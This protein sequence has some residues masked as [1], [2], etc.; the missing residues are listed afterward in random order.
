VLLIFLICL[1]MFH[2]FNLIHTSHHLNSQTIYFFLL[3]IS[4]T[5]TL[6]NLDLLSFF[7]GTKNFHISY[8]FSLV[9]F[10]NLY[11]KFLLKKMGFDHHVI[12]ISLFF[13][14]I[15]SWILQGLV[16]EGRNIHKQSGFHK[17][18]FFFCLPSKLLFCLSM[19][20]FTVKLSELGCI[21]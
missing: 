21:I 14:V 10:Y 6:I 17:V 5:L 20:E 1:S 2:H 8:Y 12:C 16:I 15:S 18:N 11:Y 3:I 9:S 13:L 19:F 4:Y 7:F